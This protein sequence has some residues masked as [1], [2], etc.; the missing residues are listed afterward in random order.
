MMLCPEYGSKGKEECSN[1][2]NDINEIGKKTHVGSKFSIKLIGKEE[3]NNERIILRRFELE[4]NGDYVPGQTERP[5]LIVEHLHNI[6][7]EDDS[8]S[9]T[10]SLYQDVKFFINHMLKHRDISSVSP[11]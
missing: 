3:F 2:W 1:Y 5:P 9:L 4:Y 6:D 11:E 8:A 10:E 7:W